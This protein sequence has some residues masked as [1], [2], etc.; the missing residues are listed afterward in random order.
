MIKDVV[1]NMK[2]DEKTTEYKLEYD[3]DAYYF[4]GPGCREE[5]SRNPKKWLK[6]KGWWG[7]FLDRLIVANEEQFQDKP[8]SCH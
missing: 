2:V 7:K 6:R 1:C 4:C 8:P 3:G 5:F